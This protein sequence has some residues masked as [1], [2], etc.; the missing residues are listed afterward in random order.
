[1]SETSR[2]G[3]QTPPDTLSPEDATVRD[4]VWDATLSLIASR[5]IPFQAW[6]VRK[7]AGLD[8]SND[9]TIRRTLTVM[10][11]AGWL[12]HETNSKWWYPGPKAE[13]EFRTDD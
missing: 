1:M 3:T 5:P 11:E 8:R 10:E 4:R 12:E 9:R 7:R 2:T 13:E 6:R